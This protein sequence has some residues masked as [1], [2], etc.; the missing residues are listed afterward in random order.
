MAYH[1]G[2]LLAQ[3]GYTVCNGGYGGTMEASACGAKDARGKTIGVVAELFGT[4]AN[5]FTDE[6]ILTKTHAERLL[7]LIEAG[8]AYVVLE[9]S[10]G[11]LLEF[12]TA[13][14]YAN[15]GII[16]N[17]PIMIIGSFWTNVV[18]TLRHQLEWEGNSSAAQYITM[19]DSPEECVRILGGHFR[20]KGFGVKRRKT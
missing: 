4:K 13:W 14:E 20:V 15:K 5:P 10:T 6:T 8:D 3:G 18:D 2:R 1:L 19:V 12:A 11:T 16:K 7:K 9:G 17:K